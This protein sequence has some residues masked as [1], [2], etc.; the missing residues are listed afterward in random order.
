MNAEIAS[1]IETIARH[2]GFS[3]GATEAMW[4]A[5]VRGNGGMAQF[6]HPDFGG[7]GQW[8]RGG[9]TMVGDMFNNSLKSRVAALC[10]ELSQLFEN[11]PVSAGSSAGSSSSSSNWW[12]REFGSPSSAG[13]Q[14]STR[15]AYF[16]DARRLAV[17]TDGRVS[18][19]DTGDHDI[20]GVSQQ[21]SGSSSV[22][23]TSQHGPVSLKEL[24]LISS[25]S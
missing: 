7:S 18:I 8:M 6:S 10:D 12:P 21:Q 22:A 5:I 24:P 13:G 9:M 16:R 19:Y 3:V 20:R 2:Q 17:D 23:F 15:Y 25:G 1:H 4:Q 14:N 11:N